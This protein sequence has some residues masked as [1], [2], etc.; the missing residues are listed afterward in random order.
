MRTNK[1]AIIEVLLSPMQ[2]TPSPR[3]LMAKERL[4]DPLGR[5]TVPTFQNIAKQN[6]PRIIIIITI[7]GTVGLAEGIIDE[8]CLIR[9]ATAVL[10]NDEY[11]SLH[12]PYKNELFF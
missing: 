9:N 8:K 10:M 1:K 2:V 12:I 4:F 3:N 7:G 11:F 5:P 6:K